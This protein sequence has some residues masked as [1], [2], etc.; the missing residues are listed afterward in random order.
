MYSGY[1]HL[2]FVPVPPSQQPPF[3]IKSSVDVRKPQRQS[4]WA[5]YIGLGLGVTCVTWSLAYVK[6]VKQR[7]RISRGNPHAPE[8]A[9]FL[10][11]VRHSIARVICK[12]RSIVNANTVTHKKRTNDVEGEEEGAVGPQT[13]SAV[14]YSQPPEIIDDFFGNTNTTTTLYTHPHQHPSSSVGGGGGV[15]TIQSHHSSR[16]GGVHTIQSHHSSR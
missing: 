13:S 10:Q 9:T 15:H 4:S 11:F 5:L 8:K 7:R 14:F 6:Y 1:S 3:V 12:V 16:R 2:H